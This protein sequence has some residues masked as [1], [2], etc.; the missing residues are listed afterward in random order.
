M[1]YFLAIG[2]LFTAYSC[3]P[4]VSAMKHYEN[5]MGYSQM[6]QIAQC[7]KN[8]RNSY[9]AETR[10]R[11]SSEGDQLV[12]YADTLAQSVREGR[13]SDSQAKLRLM[14]TVANLR[15]S[16]AIQAAIIANAGDDDDLI[17]KGLGMVGGTRDVGGQLKTK[18]SIPPSSQTTITTRTSPSTTTTTTS[19]PTG[20]QIQNCVEMVIS[21][22][23]YTTK[24]VCN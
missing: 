24:T 6:A 23:P 15:Q 4:Y 19:P 1:R 14:E 17:N 13:M 5:C 16:A 2:L 7:G 22:N 11:R 18:P 8:S 3:T 12:I 21:R 10:S 20:K 9:L